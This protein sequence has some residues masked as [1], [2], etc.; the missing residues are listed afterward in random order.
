MMHLPPGTTIERYMVEH[1]IG[2]GGVATVYAVRHAVLGTRHALKVLR[3]SAPGARARLLR[4]GRLQA[5]LD[6]SHIVPVTDVLEVGGAPALLMPLV[7]GCSLA[8]LLTAHRLSVPEA[9]ALFA[10]IAAGVASAHSA[11]AVHR[12]LKPANVLLDLQEGAVVPRVADFGLAHQDDGLLLTRGSG[13]MGTPRM[14][15]PSSCAAQRR[16]SAPTCSRWG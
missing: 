2:V 12:D 11:G 3:S 10:G 14:P 15:P 5:R 6:P 16:T 9:S 1:Q 8:H 7:D 13:F 4:E